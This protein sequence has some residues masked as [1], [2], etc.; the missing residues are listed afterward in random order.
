MERALPRYGDSGVTVLYL[1]G[2]LERDNCP[3]RGTANDAFYNSKSS[4]Q[5]MRRE[6]ASALAVTSRDTPCEML[7]GRPGFK[8]LMA[9]AKK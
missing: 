9:T 3:I 2:V 5:M 1:M 4:V 7:G 8:N 6:S